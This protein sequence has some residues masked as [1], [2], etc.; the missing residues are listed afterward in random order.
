M[1]AELDNAVP[2][3]FCW[4]EL[5]TTDQKGGVAF[6]RALFGWDSV[7]RPLG[8]GEVYTMFQLR[9]REVAA[10]SG[11]RPEERQGGVP[12]HWN[13]YVS[14]ESA[15]AAATRAQELGGAVVLPPFDVFDAG[16]MAVFQDPTG[17]FISVWQPRKHVGARVL[18]EPGA[19]CWTELITHDPMAAETFYTSLFGWT[20]KTTDMGGGNQYTEVGNRG[21]MIGGIMKARPEWGAMPSRWTPYF[22][23]VNCDQAASRATGLGGQLYVP[24]TDI[25]NVGRFATVADPQGG[26]FAIFTPAHSGAQASVGT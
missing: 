8:P 22:A 20:M 26:T 23:V 2:G 25:P 13:S 18:N 11:M 19:L 15:D 7:D 16:R 4:P 9:G 3:S 10:A 14:V 12:T 1:M 21:S 17:A 6:Y 5:T 24:P